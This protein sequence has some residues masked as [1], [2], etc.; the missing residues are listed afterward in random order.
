MI[1][2]EPTVIAI[3]CRHPSGKWHK[4]SSIEAK[5]GDDFLLLPSAKGIVAVLGKVN[6]GDLADILKVVEEP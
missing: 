3:I 4:V 1:I 6:D 2:K 5:Q